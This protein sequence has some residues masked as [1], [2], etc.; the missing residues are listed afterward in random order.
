MRTESKNKLL[1][2]SCKKSSFSTYHVINIE[3]APYQ[4]ESLTFIGKLRGKS[5][6]EVILYDNGYNPRKAKPKNG[7]LRTELMAIA[8]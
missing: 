7:I 1:L 3:N 5:E 6:E 4:R 2:N 8:L